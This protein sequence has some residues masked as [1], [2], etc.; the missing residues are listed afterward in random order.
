ML[1]CCKPATCPGCTPAIKTFHIQKHTAERT[2]DAR[3]DWREQVLTCGFMSCWEFFLSAHVFL[4]LAPC[5]FYSSFLLYVYVLFQTS[6]GTMSSRN[7]LPWKGLRHHIDVSLKGKVWGRLVCWR[8]K[9]VN[10]LI[11]IIWNKTWSNVADKRLNNALSQILSFPFKFL[12]MDIA[13]EWI[14]LTVFTLFYKYVIVR[15]QSFFWCT[16]LQ[17]KK[18]WKNKLCHLFTCHALELIT[19]FVKFVM[20]MKRFLS[21]QF[22]ALVAML[23]FGEVIIGV[24]AY[25]KRNEVRGKWEKLALGCTLVRTQ[26]FW[27]WWVCS[28]FR[29]KGRKQRS[30]VLHQLVYSVCC[31]WRPGHRRQSHILP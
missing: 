14:V 4:S 26:H 11:K 24:L 3:E 13:L 7:I 2:M 19:C 25:S 10:T 27:P 5:L 9:S 29:N 31:H 18:T 23:A 28:Y 1:P 22:I 20:I 12:D 30:R 16:C 6:T 8:D 15:Y 17:D 21:L